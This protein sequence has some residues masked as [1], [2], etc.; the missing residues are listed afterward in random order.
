MIRANVN[1]NTYKA[2]YKPGDIIKEKLSPADMAYLRKHKFITVEDELLNTEEPSDSEDGFDGFGY[3]ED[4]Q[5]DAGL[6][7]MDETALQ[8]LKKDELVEY[9]A[10][11]G[12]ELDESMLKGELIEAILN[13]VEEQAAG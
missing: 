11:L 9:A 8:K 1:I 7:Y 6:E 4:G 2:E 10:K 3:G 13:H 5:Q 12:L